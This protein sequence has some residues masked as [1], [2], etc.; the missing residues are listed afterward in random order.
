[1]GF[2]TRADGVIYGNTKEVV[3]ESVNWG[4]QAVLFSDWGDQHITGQILTVDQEMN[5]SGLIGSGN[6]A[7]GVIEG[8]SGLL[9]GNGAEFSVNK[10]YAFKI[11]PGQEVSVTPHEAITIFIVSKATDKNLIKSSGVDLSRLQVVNTTARTDMVYEYESLGQEIF[12]PSYEPGLGLLTFTF[13][14]DKIP[15]HRH[16]YSDRLIRVIAGNGYT[17]ANPELYEMQ[18]GNFCLFP[19]NMVHTNGPVPGYI[20]RV[21]AFQ[22]PWV[23][24]HI[25]E[26]NIGG[27]PKF[28][29][30]EGPTL[31]KELWKKKEDFYRAI[32]NLSAK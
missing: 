27:D 28:V 29:Q 6:E 30:Y 22:I 25:D 18:E 21:Y 31:P 15:L 20:Y 23:S 26:E 14:I 11:L 9:H 13:P 2:I 32:K 12:T 24:S 1:M 5:L 10:G 7:V 4:Q 16:P 17:Y 3:K 19:K 8:G